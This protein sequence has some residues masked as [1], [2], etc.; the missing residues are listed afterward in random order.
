MAIILT[1]IEPSSLV[2]ELLLKVKT[3]DDVLS[4][5]VLIRS[6]GLFRRDDSSQ[7]P[8]TVGVLLVPL[9]IVVYTQFRFDDSLTRWAWWLSIKLSLS[10]SQIEVVDV[11]IISFVMF[12]HATNLM[13]Q[14]IDRFNGRVLTRSRVDKS[15]FPEIFP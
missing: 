11:D 8:H 14:S 15:Q 13:C 7:S 10:K 4:F 5:V 6:Q 9:T 2:D 12:H 3:D 1:G